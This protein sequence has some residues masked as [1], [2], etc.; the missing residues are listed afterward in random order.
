MHV[1]RQVKCIFPSPG[2]LRVQAWMLI[3]LL[4]SKEYP[5][6][7]RGFAFVEFYNHA[8][9][10]AAKNTLSAPH[11]P[12]R[13]MPPHAALLTAPRSF[14]CTAQHGHAAAACVLHIQR[15]LMHALRPAERA[16][17]PAQM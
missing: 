15:I 11:L 9:A 14:S 13:L 16:G 6:Q 17:I 8:C 5:G 3:E 7:N 4:L 12:V 1:P 2:R 10:Q